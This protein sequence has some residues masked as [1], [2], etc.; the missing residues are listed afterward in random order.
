[1]G[2]DPMP[3]PIDL[4]ALPDPERFW[5]EIL[6]ADPERIRRAFDRLAADEAQLVLAHLRRMATEKGW[7]TAQRESSGAAL[8]ALEPPPSTPSEHR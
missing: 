7:H 4:P 5:A 1:M 2:D 8:R 6:S 3:Q